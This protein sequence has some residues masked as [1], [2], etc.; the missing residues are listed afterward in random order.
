M[1]LNSLK[2]DK[3]A[4]ALLKDRLEAVIIQAAVVVEEMK[5]VVKRPATPVL[6]VL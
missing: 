4:Y 3:E 2:E 5:I 1:V 6:L